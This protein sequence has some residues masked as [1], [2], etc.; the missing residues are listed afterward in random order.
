MPAHNAARFIS[1]AIGSVIWQTHDDWELIIVDDKSSDDTLAICR[2]FSADCENIKVIALSVNVGPAEARNR[3]LEVVT[4]RYVAFLDSDDLWLP[5]F[6][7]RMVRFSIENDY[8]FC[9]SS[10]YIANSSLEVSRVYDVPSVV[11][12]DRL[13]VSTDISC[14]T[15][16]IEA[17][18]VAGLKM[19]D[20]RYGEDLLFWVDVLRVTEVAHGLPVPL[21]IYRAGN[22]SSGSK[23]GFVSKRWRLYR[24]GFKYSVIRSLW[25]LALASLNVAKKY[26]APRS[27]AGMKDSYEQGVSNVVKFL[28]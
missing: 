5:D 13:P 12:R 6:L 9:F 19:R 26:Y 21:A 17:N 23:F 4:G 16:F 22:I 28:A 7:E 25:S 24:C 8:Q 15:A 14:L 18:V 2:K 3:A 20:L 1:Q 27:T 10:Y 11:G